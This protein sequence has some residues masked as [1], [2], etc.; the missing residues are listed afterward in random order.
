MASESRR[1]RGRYHRQLLRSA[2]LGGLPAIVITLALLWG[3]RHSAAVRWTLT[4]AVVGFWLGGALAVRRTV[5]RS[6]QTLS[7]VLAALRQGDFSVRI[8]AAGAGDALGLA[9]LEANL[10]GEMLRVQRLG[11]LEATALMERVMEEIEVAVFAF[12]RKGQLRL[13]NRAGARLL[14]QPEEQLLGRS[15]EALGL[16]AC[17]S[18]APQRA[19]E[20]S[21]PGARGRWEIRRSTFRQGGLP[22]E[23]LVLTDIGRPVREG[24]LEAWRRLVRVLSHEINNSLTP[25]RSIAGSLRDGLLRTPRP[26]DW[27]ADL[28]RGLAVI[29]N[30]ADALG[31]FI[32]R[33]ARVTRL[34]QPVLDSVDVEAWI[35]RVAALEVRLP[36][37]V[38]SGPPV[39]VRAD[40]HQLDQLLINLLRNAVDASLE[41]GGGVTVGWS[42]AGESLEVRVVD[43]GPGLAET[44]NLFVPFFTTKPSGSGIGL[45]LGRQ[46][47]EAHGGTLTLTNREGGRGAEAVL[48]L[49][50]GA[51]L[52]ATRA[53]AGRG[54]G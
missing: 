7:N 48:S 24:E 17:L 5:V 42:V 43:E 41:T 35:R 23:L 1:P 20:M 25:I 2:L 18:G 12:D 29:A 51:T 44:A 4:L 28:D 6:L 15:I 8:R 32:A 45:A 14:A 26:V 54:F 13:V 36:V 33:Y 3:G 31:H 10:L 50:A 37:C 9:L 53:T 34:P 11:A 19:I 47:A 52:G 38:R 40:G 30:R 27:E 39:S 49:P 46:I 21:F 22:H 16:S